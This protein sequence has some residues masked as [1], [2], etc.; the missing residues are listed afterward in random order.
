MDIGRHDYNKIK[1]LLS[2]VKSKIE[3]HTEFKKEYN[4]Q[5]AFDFN[6]FNFF[7]VG[8]N[9]VSEILAFFLNPQESH[10]Q[11]DVFLKEFV[12][13]FYKED[14]NLSNA[15]I[16]CEK[17][18]T[19]KRRIDLYIKLKGFT[20]AIE[21]KIW[22]DDQPN[23]LKDYATFLEK[24]TKGKFLLLYLNPYGSLPTE[25]SIDNEYKEELFSNKQYKRIS[26][27]NDILVL[28]NKWAAICE[29]GNVTFFINE[30]KKYLK[31]KFLGNNTINMSTKLREIIYNNQDEV[32]ALVKEYN[33]IGDEIVRKLNEVGKELDNH[34]PIL[35]EGL[36]LSKSGLF[37]WYGTRVYKYSIS[38]GV[39]KIWIQLVREGVFL[40]SNY[41]FQDGTDEK[42]KEITQN[43]NLNDKLI[44]DHKRSKSELINIFIEQVEKTNEIFEEFDKFIKDE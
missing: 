7:N 32:T 8:E 22:A 29:A 23:Q 5:L 1:Q 15:Y 44:L 35:N 26:Y 17:I 13:Q 41:Y 20:I 38:K 12:S 21:N 24:E 18:I 2:I 39:N 40:Y 42:F 3:A 4:K 27:Q 31:I 9:K 28:I 16:E 19:N 11:G 37:N 36:T 33:T 34:N 6:L 30:F 14:V 43:L 25:K 10:G